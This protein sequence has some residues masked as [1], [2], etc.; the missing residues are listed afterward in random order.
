MKEALTVTALTR[1]LKYKFTS[2]PHLQDVRLD[3]E[4]SNFKHH[5]RGHFYFTLKDEEAAISAV[6]F[7]GDATQVTFHPK[8]GDHVVVDGYISIFEKAGSYQIY[9]KAMR[10]EGLG[11]LY[12]NYLALKAA[13]EKEGY[14]DASHK[15]EL[16]KFPK[17][18]A[19]LTSRT[20]AAI[21]DM[22][23]TITRRF[24]LT[25]MII[26]PTQ[27]QGETAKESIA[28]NIQRADANPSVDLIIVGRGGGSIEDLWAFNER[29]VADAIYQSTTPIISAV[30][31]ETDFTIADFVADLRA[32]TPTGAAEMAVPDQY[33][34]QS[35]IKHRRRRLDDLLER[36]LRSKEE[37]LSYVL[38]H[39]VFKYPTR[40]LEPYEKTLTHRL[41]QLTQLTPLE[42]V[43]QLSYAFDQQKRQLNRLIEKR[44]ERF[45]Y[46]LSH[47]KQSIHL[48][49]PQTRLEQGYTLI[50]HNGKLIKRVQDI[51]LKEDI[52][53]TFSDGSAIATVKSKK[54]DR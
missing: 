27:V 39:P 26:Y 14:F 46:I 42:K 7:K 30:G 51:A 43:K 21:K 23:S 36:L 33:D 52:H 19:L 41:H 50:Q 24:P 15:V 25:A 17:M 49:S 45:H 28:R 6:M 18:V 32:P 12:Q 38:S 9:V 20:G 13:L 10:Q 11:Q 40:L 1:Y 22:I 3:G 31:H 8:E 37:R 2:D 53:I 4:I 35:S 54:G 34:I 5:S 47:L 44:L 29:I 16:P 48:N